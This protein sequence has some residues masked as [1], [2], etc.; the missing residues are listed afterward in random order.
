MKRSVQK[1]NKDLGRVKG[2][3]G[4]VFKVQFLLLYFHVI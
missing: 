1:L 2:K 3:I 4:P